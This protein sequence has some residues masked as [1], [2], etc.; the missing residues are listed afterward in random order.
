MLQGAEKLSEAVACDG[1]S[2]S[3][4]PYKR[5]ARGFVTGLSYG[6]A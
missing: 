6:R 1:V 4:V 2:V 3:I 5:K